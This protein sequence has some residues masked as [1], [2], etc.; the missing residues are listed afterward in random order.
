V[1]VEKSPLMF[2]LSFENSPES[3]EGSGFMQMMPKLEN[4]AF[5]V[6]PHNTYN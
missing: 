1:Y 6:N 5:Q 4:K 2:I 3:V